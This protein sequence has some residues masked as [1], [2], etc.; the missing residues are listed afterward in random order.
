MHQVPGRPPA[1][2]GKLPPTAKLYINNILNI[3]TFEQNLLPNIYTLYYCTVFKLSL[4]IRKDKDFQNDDL[5][6]EE[7]EHL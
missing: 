2:D 5:N 6:E 1:E 3:T 7:D 4:A